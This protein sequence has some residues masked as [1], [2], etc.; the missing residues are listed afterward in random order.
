MLII[1]PPDGRG[2]DTPELALL[3]GAARCA[4]LTRLLMARALRWGERMAPGRVRVAAPGR[5]GALWAAAVG[6]GRPQFV[7]WPELAVWRPEHGAGALDD[8]AA[9]ATISAGPLFDGGLY[10]LALAGPVPWLTDLPTA[11]GDHGAA[12]GAMIAAASAAGE[13]IGLLRAERALRR[14]ADVHALLADPLL[15]PELAAILAPG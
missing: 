10:L 11:V 3:L 4:E 9:G 1:G 5:A 7:V 6:D 13:E 12:L 2:A 8:L 15:D 14:P